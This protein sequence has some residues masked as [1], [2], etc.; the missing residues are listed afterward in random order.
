MAL[1]NPH[2]AEIPAEGLHAVCE[3]QPEELGLEAEDARV[4]GAL[5]LS[6]DIA[7][8]EQG[9]HVT[10]VLGGTFLRQCVR[11]LAE[12]KESVELPFTAE[13]RRETP[14]PRR[15]PQ[16]SRA[17]G[18]AGREGIESRDAAEPDEPEVEVEADDLHPLVGDRLDLA[19]MLREQIILATPMQPLCRESCLGLCPVC[20]QDRNERQCGCP[21]ERQDGPFAILKRL[22]GK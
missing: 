11:C 9:A 16:S 21:E 20:G 22:Q 3:V 17:P 10:G 15:Q 19:E 2:L 14:P 18:R 8:F 5:T 6:A 7:P 13:Y 1:P 4:E 12:F